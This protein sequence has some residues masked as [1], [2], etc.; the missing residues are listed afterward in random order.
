[1]F[2]VPEDVVR[3]IY[4]TVQTA[5]KQGLYGGYYLDFLERSVGRKLRGGEYSVSSRA[6]EHLGYDPPGGYGGPDPRGAAKE[7][8]RTLPDDPKVH[9]AVQMEANARRIIRNITRPNLTRI[10]ADLDILAHAA[11]E[12]DV[13]AD[14]FEETGR[15]VHAGTLREQARLARRGDYKLLAAYEV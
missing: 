14:L 9:E 15:R 4:A 11:D 3:R 6:K 8:R 13:A 12:L 1:M 2:D 5:K 7:P 10:P